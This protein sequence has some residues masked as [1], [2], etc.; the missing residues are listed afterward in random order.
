MAGASSAWCVVHALLLATVASGGLTEGQ[1]SSEGLSAIGE[2]SKG[3]GAPRNPRN[4]AQIPTGFMKTP[5]VTTAP[6]NTLLF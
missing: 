5:E 3:E 2:Q 6:K 4:Q 1:Q